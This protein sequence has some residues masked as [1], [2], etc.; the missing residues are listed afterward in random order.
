MCFPVL[1]NH[2]CIDWIFAFFF[3]NNSDMD[4][5]KVNVG[6]ESESVLL[7]PDKVLRI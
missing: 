3:K 5:M 4:V 2:V 1:D 7:F 6:D